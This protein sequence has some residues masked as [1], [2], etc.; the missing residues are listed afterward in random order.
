MPVV[1][2]VEGLSVAQ[3]PL[4]NARFTVRA[5][6]RAGE[7]MAGA[8]RQASAVAAEIGQREQQKADDAAMFEAR[9]RLAEWE[10]QQ[11]DSENPKGVTARR[12]REAL[13]LGD[14]QARA[15]EETRSRI[16]QDLQPR[17]RQAFRNLS[18]EFGLRY[19][20]RV[21][22]YS[23]Q[24]Y[25]GY[26]AANE[27]ATLTSLSERAALAGREGRLDAMADELLLAEAA[28]EEQAQ[29]LGL[30]PE[31]AAARK[32]DFTSRAMVATTSGF[33]E[34]GDY[35]GAVNFYR[36]NA[37]DMTET[38]RA[39]MDG[40]IRNAELELREVE[41]AAGIMASHGTGPGA[42]RAAERI[43]DPMLR[44]RVVARIDAESRRRQQA[45]AQAEAAVIAQ[46][47]NAVAGTD[48]ATPIDRAVPPDLLVAMNPRDR[49]ALHN[50]QSAR[51]RGEEIQTDPRVYTDLSLMPSEKLLEVDLNRLVIER[52]LHPDHANRFRARQEEIRNPK[53]ASF[54]WSSEEDMNRQMV[55]TLGIAED[56]KAQGKY[57][58]AVDA[59]VA[60]REREL[61]R[62]LTKQEHWQLLNELAVPVMRERSFLGIELSPARERYYQVQG[63]TEGFY[64]DPA[65]TERARNALTASRQA[66][67]LPPPT[68]ADVSTFVRANAERFNRE[69]FTDGD[70]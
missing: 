44:D 58:M 42:V 29:R 40:T 19:R 60:Q 20:E 47:Y 56:K 51:L 9:S 68:D 46:A 13:G 43:S 34:Q 18:G 52:Q 36:A 11:F 3:A 7:A 53:A 39:R 31:V 63:E 27:E 35:A 70:E 55:H 38:D 2:R 28:I 32:A 21:D 1:P 66:A 12:G 45:Q 10:R 59:A 8:L 26:L 37:D 69:G 65:I 25:E 61:D 57:R 23:S 30:G 41:E 49:M 67:G 17:Q 54:R 16:E 24:Q 14:D 15:Y 4:P 48:P 64:L 33:L 22:R 62:S 6:G 5:D 50:F